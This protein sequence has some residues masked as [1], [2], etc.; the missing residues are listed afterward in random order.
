MSADRAAALVAAATLLAACA[1]VTTA[2]GSRLAFASEEF[3]AYVERVFRSQNEVAS[4]LAF[5]LED[6]GT[7]GGEGSPLA[8]AEDALLGAC[9]GL[10]EL[11]TSR[12][13]EQRLGLRR[14]AEAARKAPDCER[15]T[16]AARAAIAAQQK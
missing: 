15:A 2:D 10:N 9:E 5:A 11:A 13:D 4:K 8:A 1:S 7:S 6:V 14:S 3:R 16:S 12:R